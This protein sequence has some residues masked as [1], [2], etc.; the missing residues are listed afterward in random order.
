MVNC[1]MMNNKKWL[2]YFTYVTRM[3][4]RGDR[5]PRIVVWDGKMNWTFLSF[6]GEKGNEI[7]H[8][9]IF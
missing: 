1:E 2:K 8:L 7:R 3:Q 4:H 5:P 6:I 9:V